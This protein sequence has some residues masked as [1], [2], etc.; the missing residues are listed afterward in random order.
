[1]LGESEDSRATKDNTRVPQQSHQHH[2]SQLIPHK[3]NCRPQSTT[4]V[5]KT[6]QEGKSNFLS[7]VLE[8]AIAQ[9]FYH[10]HTPSKA[11]LL[12]SLY[13]ITEAAL[14]GFTL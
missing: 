6:L 7:E 10:T 3:K 12:N 5:I 4:Q 14:N 13:R 11:A 8:R 1:M 2:S 9:H